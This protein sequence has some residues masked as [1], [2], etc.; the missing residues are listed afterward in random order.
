MKASIVDMTVAA[1]RKDDELLAMLLEM[2]GL[3][4]RKLE[5]R[6]QDCDGRTRLRNALADDLNLTYES[7]SRL[8]VK[9]ARAWGL[10]SDIAREWEIAVERVEAVLESVHGATLVRRALDT[11]EPESDNG[12][13]GIDGNDNSSPSDVGEPLANLGTDWSSPRRIP[14]VLRALGFEVPDRLRAVRFRA[15]LEVLRG[16]GIDACLAEDPTRQVLDFDSSSPGIAAKLCLR[17]SDSLNSFVGALQTQTGTNAVMV[18]W[19]RL[20]PIREFF[21]RLGLPVPDKFGQQEFGAFVEALE[22]RGFEV[23]TAE[24]VH[25]SPLHDALC[26]DAEIRVRH[27]ALSASMSSR[28]FDGDRQAGSV[29]RG[30][31][32]RGDYEH[33]CLRLEL[34]TASSS[35]MPS[36]PELLFRCV[37]VAVAGLSIHATQRRLLLRVAEAMMQASRNPMVV[38]MGLAPRLDREDGQVLLNEYASLYPG[39][40]EQQALLCEHWIELCGE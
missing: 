39:N 11:V 17:K 29:E 14:D 20:Q 1:L 40:N 5:N 13:S 22:F 10:A 9:Q 19:S 33:A 15:V 25:I 6:L 23:A 32:L 30:T 34:L 7:L 35:P 18:G 38:L 37:D 8:T 3:T 27:D 21:G 31:H 28:H 12:A 2:T 26:M 4:R 16:R 36:S 24:G